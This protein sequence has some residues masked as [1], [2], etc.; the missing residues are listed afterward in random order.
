MP[1]NEETGVKIIIIFSVCDVDNVKISTLP[2]MR[3]NMYQNDQPL[4]VFKLVSKR[5][6][7]LVEQFGSVFCQTKPMSLQNELLKMVE[8]ALK[9]HFTSNSSSEKCRENCDKSHF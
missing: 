9:C 2:E 7:L 5:T 6:F 1:L 3:S 4:R 8:K